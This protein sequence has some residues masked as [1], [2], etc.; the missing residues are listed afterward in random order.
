M[1]EDTPTYAIPLNEKWLEAQEKSSN[2]P[3]RDILFLNLHTQ[4]EDAMKKDK[5]KR[6]FE[7]NE[8]LKL[9]AATCKDLIKPFQTVNQFI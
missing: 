8:N 3:V 6:I 2:H 1:D 4:L 9:S 5:K 7:K